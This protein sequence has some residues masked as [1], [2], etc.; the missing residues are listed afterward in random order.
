MPEP[1]RHLLVV[2]PG[3]GRRT[4]VEL[5]GTSLWSAGPS[6]EW[7]LGAFVLA[8]GHRLGLHLV[9]DEPPLVRVLR[10]DGRQYAAEKI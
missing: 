3:T 9:Q 8:F 10:E 5:L 2:R 4:V 7:A 1:A 6:P